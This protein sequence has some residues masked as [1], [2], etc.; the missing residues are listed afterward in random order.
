MFESFCQAERVPDSRMLSTLFGSGLNLF[1]QPLFV[2]NF[3]LVITATR[4]FS[5]ATKQ[6]PY[7]FLFFQT[8]AALLAL[9]V[10]ASVLF[11]V[12]PDE[13]LLKTL[14]KAGLPLCIL[15]RHSLN[16]YPHMLP[17]LLLAAAPFIIADIHAASGRGRDADVSHRQHRGGS[18]RHA[19]RYL[20]RATQSP[21]L[22]PRILLQGSPLLGLGK[23]IHYDLIK[24][25]HDHVAK[26]K[27]TDVN[28]PRH[29]GLAWYCSLKI[30]GRNRQLSTICT[31]WVLFPVVCY[32]S[33]L[34]ALQQPDAPKLQIRHHY[35]RSTSLSLESVRGFL[36]ARLGCS[37]ATP[38]L[39]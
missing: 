5:R 10:I 18:P 32:A 16:L 3:L 17:P 11:G 12:V 25:E 24:G 38:G 8:F 7:T 23:S 27:L 9:H 34:R 29:H 4:F 26:K 13:H 36:D 22:T 37:R 2:I 21:V 1:F 15:I 35:L 19:L 20:L 39:T 14:F 6:R 33:C 31:S 30:N 28:G